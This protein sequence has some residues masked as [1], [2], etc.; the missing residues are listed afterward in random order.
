MLKKNSLQ[1]V[2][3]L[4]ALCCSQSLFAQLSPQDAFKELGRGINIGNTFDPPEGEGKWNNGPLQEYYFDDYKAA[5]FST[6][7]IPITW[8]KHTA[9]APPYAVDAAWM[10][11]IEQIVDWGLARGLYI[12]I[13]AHHEDSIKTDY[14]RKTVRDRFDSTWS[15]IA[16]RFK[17]KSDKL[18]FEIINE[19][20]PI[21]KANIDELNTRI[22]GIIRKT[23]PTRIVVFSGN[24]WANSAELISA[25][26]PDVNDKYLMAYYHSYDPW[27]F[28]GLAKG[29]YGSAADVSGTISKF[30]QVSTWSVSKNIPVILDEFGAVVKS[31][32]NSRMKYLA[33]V[34]EQALKHNIGMC[35]WDDG[36]DFVSYNRS[37]RSWSDAK[38]VLIYTST[39][40]PTN[41][42][43]SIVA[44]ST[45]KISWVNKTNQNGDIHIE[46]KTSSGKFEEIGTVS[47]SSTEYI[48]KTAK[49]GT[50]YYYR[51]HTTISPATEL[52][53]YPQ[54]VNIVSTVR[55]PYSGKAISIPGTVEAENFDKGGEGLSY[56]DDDLANQGG[57]YRTEEAVDIESLSAGGYQVGYLNAGEWQEYSIAVADS[58]DYKIECTVASMDGGGKFNFS[59]KKGTKTV[60]SD[61][62]L[63]PKT[64]GWQTMQTV[65]TNVAIP[66]GNL[67]MRVNTNAV[68]AFNLDKF[69][70]TKNVKT[71]IEDQ[72]EEK[73]SIYPNPA[74]DNICLKGKFDQN[75]IISVT[76]IYGRI[77]IRKNGLTDSDETV[78][79]D[80]SG[81]TA[82]VYTLTLSSKKSTESKS[83]VKE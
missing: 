53:S 18:F 59:F 58:G 11:R 39:A 31:D 48:D 49:N 77:V 69:V 54:M 19:P 8:C 46:R 44:D 36:G 7:R 51:V 42:Q 56:H 9:S 61:D 82:G 26:V 12:I 72:K 63:V 16:T 64:G 67:I 23:N 2:V 74:C 68:P 75:S 40:S 80:I 60:N 17:K 29:T 50:I 32:Y 38:D 3:L 27:D 65:S 66:A 25:R 34:T 57:A 30:D 28:A 52:Y 73:F 83:F 43:L 21:S 37:Q 35:Y 41:L 22:L 71:G 70:F 78:R 13:N 4:I 81:L 45:V 1:A 6:I 62:V 76:D 5:G 15:Q 55:T 14:S 24:E 79:L 33:T 20:R 10:N 47:A